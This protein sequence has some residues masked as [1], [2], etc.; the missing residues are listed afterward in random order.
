M[1]KK[2]VVGSD[3]PDPPD[4]ESLEEVLF[5]R[6]S[7]FYSELCDELTP[8]DLEYW[9]DTEDYLHHLIKQTTV[10]VLQGETYIGPAKY[11]LEYQAVY[12]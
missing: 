8:K 12:L 6:I 2:P 9:S 7:E 4:N 10:K 1:V 5:K 11:V 3:L